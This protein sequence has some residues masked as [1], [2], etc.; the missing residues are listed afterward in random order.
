MFQPF[1]LLSS[2]T[3][4]VGSSGICRLGASCRGHV[5]ELFGKPSTVLF[6]FAGDVRVVNSTLL[7]W[8]GL[9]L[10]T[11]LLEWFSLS[12]ADV[13]DFLKLDNFALSSRG[14]E[15]SAILLGWELLMVE[16]G[17]DL[18]VHCG[19]ASLLMNP[20]VSLDLGLTSD[21]FLGGVNPSTKVDSVVNF[22]LLGALPD[23]VWRWMLLFS[24]PE[25][26]EDDVE[27]WETLRAESL[28]S[29]VFCPC[30]SP[31]AEGELVLGVAVSTG[32]RGTRLGVTCPHVLLF[33]GWLLLA[34]IRGTRLGVIWLP[35]AFTGEL[36]TLTC[37]WAGINAVFL[38]EFEA[39]LVTCCTVTW[40]AGLETTG[41]GVK[42]ILLGV[43]LVSGLVGVIFI[44]T[45]NISILPAGSFLWVGWEDLSTFSSALHLSIRADVCLL[46]IL[47]V[48]QLNKVLSNACECTLD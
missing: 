36:P 23:E 16:A 10:G 19:Y 33:L 32:V 31:V 48:K 5:L 9:L 3:I 14:T 41:T 39:V 24:A 28:L 43:A 47:P 46:P 27:T 17:V 30:L 6:L 21:D 26:R 38:P 15:V 11:W 2:K 20:T 18:G 8:S 4:I 34:G 12:A 40:L 13:S 7:G 22:I 44:G 1:Q 42:V 29:E 35:I 45:A 25:S 37:F